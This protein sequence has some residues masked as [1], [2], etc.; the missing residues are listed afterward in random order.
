MGKQPNCKELYRQSKSL[1]ERDQAYQQLWKIVHRSVIR[2]IARY[3]ND[4]VEDCIQ[5]ALLRVYLKID[6]CRDAERFCG[7]VRM[8]A[9]RIVID[10]V[11][12]L[13]DEV[14]I[15]PFDPPAPE[16]AGIGKID[17]AIL[18]EIIDAA[19]ISERSHRVVTGRYWDHEN[20]SDLAAKEI[21]HSDDEVRP[22]HIQVTRSRNI[23]KL[24]HHAPLQAFI[25]S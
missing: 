20:D 2:N 21:E 5:D 15:E 13:R 23:R 14:G 9:R 22:S 12:A 8:I 18:R 16:P 19:P 24:R 7:W 3:G 4:F 17:A 6:Q 25:D 10:R 11:N 1:A